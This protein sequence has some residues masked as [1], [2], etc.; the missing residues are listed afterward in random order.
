MKCDYNKF[1]AHLGT[2]P[3]TLIFKLT[4][5]GLSTIIIDKS[6]DELREFLHED[7]EQLLGVLIRAIKGYA[8]DGNDT[9]ENKFR[10]D[11]QD[12]DAKA[13]SKEHGISLELID[14]LRRMSVFY[15]K[16]NLDT[17]TLFQTEWVKQ[18]VQLYTQHGIQF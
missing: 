6:G 8:D 1:V 15:S 16:E 13:F 11:I 10:Q 2:V 14:V 4:D 7:V 5:F 3:G 18:F 12:K 17:D 9:R